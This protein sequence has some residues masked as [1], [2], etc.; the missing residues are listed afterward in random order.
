MFLTK[1]LKVY[2]GKEEFLSLSACQ[3]EPV[4]RATRSGFRSPARAR[5]FCLLRIFQTDAG[6]H[7]VFCTLVTDF[8]RVRK[9]ATGVY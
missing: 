8:R 9:I 7:P 4:L 2:R 6:A 3:Q 5:D 1:T